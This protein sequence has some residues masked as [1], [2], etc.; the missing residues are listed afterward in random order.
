MGN[1]TIASTTDTPEEVQ[2]ALGLEPT[3]ADSAAPEEGDDT[4]SESGA[5]SGSADEKDDQIKTG[6]AAKTV[7]GDESDSDDNA[8]DDDDEPQPQLDASGKPVVKAKGGFQKRIER[9]NRK[10]GSLESTVAQQNRMNLELQRQLQENQRIINELRT[11]K[12]AA[13]PE[14]VLRAQPVYDANKHASYQEFLQDQGAWMKEA[15]DHGKVTADK[16]YAAKLTAEV[17][18]IQQGV[19]QTEAQKQAQARMQQIYAE[20]GNRQSKFVE[21]V[22]AQG[23]DF[24]AIIKTA[25]AAGLQISDEMRGVMLVHE[26]GPQ[27][28]LWYAEHPQEVQRIAQFHPS[29]QHVELGQVIASFKSGSAAAPNRKKSGAPK[30]IGKVGTGG[31]A[32][33]TGVHSVA[34]LENL[35]YQDYKKARKEMQPQA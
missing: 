9:S 12:P 28:A 7:A 5:E 30:P 22:K 25:A 16:E 29:L 13:V 1:L 2:A 11:P 34:N 24:H 17:Q 20:F 10:I 19:Q 18:K 33:K 23:K 35:S 14:P 6:V 4:S 21:E 31:T 3:P 8:D 15:I 26:K 32:A 27:L